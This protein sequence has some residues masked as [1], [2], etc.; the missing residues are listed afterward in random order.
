[1]NSHRHPGVE[2]KQSPRRTAELCQRQTFNQI[3]NK[4]CLIINLVSNSHQKGSEAVYTN[5]YNRIIKSNNSSNSNNNKKK[6]TL[7]RGLWWLKWEGN[8]KKRGYMYMYSGFTL[9]YS[10]N[11]HNI[12]QL[13]SN[14]NFKK[15][16]RTRY[17]RGPPHTG[18]GAQT[19]FL[20]GLRELWWSFFAVRTISIPISQLWRLRLGG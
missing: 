15:R 2:Q 17:T 18:P 12:K 9:L 7:S 3:A 19:S 13:Y 4:K 8:S 10:R 14:E 5:I 20:Q 16:R 1:M 6:N 11:W